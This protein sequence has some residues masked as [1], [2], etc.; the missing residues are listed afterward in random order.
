VLIDIFITHI[1][2]GRVCVIHVSFIL[3]LILYR[4][5]TPAQVQQQNKTSPVPASAARK[6]IQRL[7]VISCRIVLTQDL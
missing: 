6:D 1:T 2:K 4:P 7:I 5:G 3:A